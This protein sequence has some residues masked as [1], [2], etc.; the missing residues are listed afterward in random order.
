MKTQKPPPPESTVLLSMG[1]AVLRQPLSKGAKGEIPEINTSCFK[2]HAILGSRMEAYIVLCPPWDQD[3]LS[4][5]TSNTK[6][7]S[8]PSLS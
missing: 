8:S 3:F 5:W 2:A 7:H 4:L 1:I 6:Y